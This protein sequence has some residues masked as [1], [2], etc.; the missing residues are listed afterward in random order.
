MATSRAAYAVENIA[1]HGEENIKQD[2]SSFDGVG[3]PGDKMKALVW[4]GKQK[5]EIGR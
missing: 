2:V 5:V 4:Q 1:G 3:D